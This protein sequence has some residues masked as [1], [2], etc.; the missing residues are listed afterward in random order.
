MLKEFKL[1]VLVENRVNNPKLLAEQGLSILIETPDGKILF[2]T[3]QTRALL[4]NAKHLNIDLSDLKYVVLSHGHYDHTGGLKYLLEEFGPLKV[5]CHPILFNKK[6]RLI[7]GERVDIGVPWERTDLENLGM[8]CIEKTRPM[9]LLPDVWTSGEIPRLTDYEKIDESYQE[10]IL[11]SYIKDEL[12]DDMA[13]ILKTEKGLVVLLGCAHSGP[14]NTVKHA[15]RIMGT[16]KLYAVM[17]GM[18]LHRAPDKKIE[19]VVH[20]LVQLQPEYVIP[21]HCSGFRTINHLFNHF[22]EHVLLF[23]VGDSF[24]MKAELKKASS[25]AQ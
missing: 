10:R 4:H 23:N 19:K 12:H 3:G 22:K 24:S 17:G 15:M 18:H 21:L 7:N 20:N 8:E 14:I 5:V 11:E 1:T 16:D 13:L 9:E 25:P 2:D 6:Y